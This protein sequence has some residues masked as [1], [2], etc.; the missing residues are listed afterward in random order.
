MCRSTFD[1]FL[2]CRALT[3]M[4]K[5]YRGHGDAGKDAHGLIS[6]IRTET[7]DT[8]GELI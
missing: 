3:V 7:L 6:E 2:V 5:Q 4:I 8:H 1:R